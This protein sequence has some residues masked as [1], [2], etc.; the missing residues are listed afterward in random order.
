MS[1]LTGL[2]ACLVVAQLAG[3]A[4]FKGPVRT[5]HAPA[6]AIKAAAARL[7]ASAVAVDPTSVQG[8]SLKTT[9]HCLRQRDVTQGGVDWDATWGASVPGPMPFE[10][11][12]PA[13]AKPT[14][15]DRCPLLF[16]VILAAEPAPDGAVLRAT[17]SWWRAE[18]GACTPEGDPLAGQARCAWRYIA[19]HRKEPATRR[20]YYTLRDL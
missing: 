10:T 15:G 12:G 14:P 6:E 17:A 20:V 18:A 4:T 5:K 3:C 7:G 2:L 19:T 1:R 16:R 11:V 8:N 13:N 9:W